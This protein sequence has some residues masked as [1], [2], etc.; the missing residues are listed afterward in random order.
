MK[1]VEISTCIQ[2]PHFGWHA[3]KIMDDKQVPAH[4]KLVDRSFVFIAGTFPDFC[5]LQDTDNDSTPMDTWETTW[6]E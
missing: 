4:C 3:V 5:P 2:C 6:A 1:M